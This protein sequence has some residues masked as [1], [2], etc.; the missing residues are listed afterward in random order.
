MN[1]LHSLQESLA[2]TYKILAGCIVERIAKGGLP[3]G[4]T[5]LQQRGGAL[6]GLTAAVHLAAVVTDKPLQKGC[7]GIVAV[8]FNQLPG[9][10]HAV[11]GQQKHGIFRTA[12]RI[13][14]VNGQG[15]AVV[16]GSG[17]HVA[18]RH[19]AEQTV[20]EKQVKGFHIFRF[21]LGLGRFGLTVAAGGTD[22]HA[23]QTNTQQGKQ[24]FHLLFLV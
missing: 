6:K 9:L 19:I 5:P 13:V 11:V 21:G 1:R 8:V 14:G 10:L 20:A 4:H 7:A 23:E 2:P 17:L 16:P 24:V 15:F 3:V 18:P 12:E 22:H